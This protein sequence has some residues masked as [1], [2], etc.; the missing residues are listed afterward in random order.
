MD[1]GTWQAIGSQRV[2]WCYQ[3]PYLW[4][5]SVNIFIYLS[6]FLD[7]CLALYNNISF[8]S[9]YSL[10][11]QGHLFGLGRVSYWDV[12]D[13]MPKIFLPYWL[14]W[15]FLVAQFIKNLPT[16]QETWV[17]S[18]GQEDPLEKEMATTPISLPG[19]F[20][21]QRRLVGYSPWGDKELDMT[22]Y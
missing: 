11:P 16:M 15:A 8:V 6:L 17:W 14:I 4:R 10:G 19:E 5:V 22:E 12:L 18:L 21:G 7:I 2:R 20:N 13:R 9:W 1:R 3:M